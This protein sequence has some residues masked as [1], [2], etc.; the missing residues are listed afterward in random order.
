M[1]DAQAAIAAAENAG[2]PEITG[3]NNEDY[4]I[5]G[6]LDPIDEVTYED[7][8]TALTE[9]DVDEDEEAVEVVKTPLIPELIVEDITNEDELEDGEE[10]EEQN[11]EVILPPPMIRDRPCRMQRKKETNVHL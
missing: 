6:V 3:V 5:T 10:T 9:E 1:T 4:I 8:D 2:M 11:E 7:K